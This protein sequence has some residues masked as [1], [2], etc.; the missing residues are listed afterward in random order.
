[1]VSFFFDRGGVEVT[2]AEGSE[3][4]QVQYSKDEIR[5]LEP[6]YVSWFSTTTKKTALAPENSWAAIDGTSR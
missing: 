6:P 3:V 1:M 2:V 5:R 4:F